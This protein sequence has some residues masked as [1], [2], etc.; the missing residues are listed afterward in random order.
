[1]VPPKLTI[2]I[3]THNRAESLNRCLRSLRVLDALSP[4]ILVFDDASSPPAVEAITTDV[5][6]LRVLR[7][8]AGP[9]QTAIGRNRLVRNASAAAVLL[10][11]DDTFLL[12]RESIEQA[13]AVLD[14]DPRIAAV[15]FAQA[16][17][18]GRPW[19]AHMQP[20]PV[21][22][23]SLVASFIG[24][25]HLVRRD[26]FMA[27]GGYRED[28]NYI[29]EEKELCLRLVD[30]GYRIVYL[31]EAAVS[32]VPDPRG[33]DQARSLRFAVRNDCLTALYND[34]VPRVLWTA[35]ARYLLYFRLRHAG[36]VRD[37]WGWLWI[38]RELV[39]R[40]KVIAARRRPVSAA[41]LRVWQELKRSPPYSRPHISN[42]GVDAA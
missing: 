39:G 14:A 6:G 17:A 41:T 38:A 28:F 40:L 18:D 25:A 36:R 21:P 29:G 35:P 4:E 22:F 3:T 27:V 19:P 42:A 23:P 15:A 8:E 9:A 20:S 13:L 10:L 16:E 5:A 30:A 24:F 31:P 33:R 2:G 34:P 7:D 12:S 26:A 11:D 1:M 37:P 32:H